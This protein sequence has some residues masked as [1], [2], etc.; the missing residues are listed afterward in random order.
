MVHVVG[1]VSG[2][3]WHVED[4]ARASLRVNVRFDPLMFPSLISR[5]G[6]GE[7]RIESGGFNL[8]EV[9][10]VLVRMMPPGSLEQVVFRM[11]VLNRLEASA[12]TVLNP[13]RAVEVAVD[14][15]LTLA[16]LGE[17]GLKVPQTWVGESASDALEQFDLLGGD[18]VVKPLFGSEGRGLLRVSDRELALRS[19]RTLERLGSVLYLQ[20]FIPNPGHD[21]RVFVLDGRILGAM[22]RHASAGEWRTNVAVGGTPKRLD[23]DPEIESLSLCA[24]E[25]VGARMAGVDL[26]RDQSGELY[27]LE[28]NA[29]PGWKALSQTCNVDVAAEILATFRERAR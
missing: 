13:P 9:D 12:T 17:A 26:L 20:R 21:I 10:G 28:V 2:L 24:A 22:T 3:G 23:V 25:A 6:R 7:T 11:D 16:V 29:V 15:F 18:I 8:R 4:L 27:I 1:L 19:F 14:K 5:V